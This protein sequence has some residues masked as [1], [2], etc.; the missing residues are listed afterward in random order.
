MDFKNCNAIQRRTYVYVQ[1]WSE[2]RRVAFS[3]NDLDCSSTGS[4]YGVGSLGGKQTVWMYRAGKWS[5]T[6]GP[7]AVG[8]LANIQ[9]SDATCIA[10]HNGQSI[11]TSKSS[12]LASSIPAEWIWE[13]GLPIPVYEGMY[14]EARLISPNS[15]S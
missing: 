11:A 2:C 5:V 15:N 3:L 13:P 9:C 8:D 14:A 1:P 6:P 10:T 4:C 12:W 7:T